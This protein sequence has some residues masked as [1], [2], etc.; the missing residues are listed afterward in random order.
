MPSLE[1]FESLLAASGEREISTTMALV[2]MLCD[3]GQGQEHRQAHRADRAGRGAHLRHGRH[4]PPD[5]H[6][7]V[8]GPAVHAAGRRPADVLQGGQEGPDP[9]GRHQRGRRAVLLDRRRHRVREPRR[10]HGAV[11]H[12]LLDVRLPARRRFL[13]GR[14][15]QPGARLPGRRHGRSHDARGR[16][17]AAPGRSQPAGGHDDAELRRVRSDASP[18]SSP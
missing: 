4:V 14:R 17:P 15:R 5:R 11:L 6:L 12:L 18:T 10:Q 3:A 2:R 7:F 1:A 8:D 16:R 9:R 13:L